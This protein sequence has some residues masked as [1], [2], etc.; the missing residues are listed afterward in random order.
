MKTLL[1]IASAPRSGS[2]LLS[3]L[4]GNFPDHFNVGEIHNL[5]DFLNE[6][7]QGKYFD[8]KCA[9]GEKVRSC[10]KWSKIIRKVV[11]T[12]G[13]VS[14]KELSTRC[15]NDLV[16]FRWR[17]LPR[18]NMA[19]KI[20]QRVQCDQEMARVAKHN[21]CLMEA[22]MEVTGAKLIINSSKNPPTLACYLCHK[23]D[24]WNIKVIHLARDPRA[25][26]L[27]MIKGAVKAGLR[28]KSYY[29]YLLGILNRRRVTECLTSMLRPENVLDLT[30]EEI[31]RSPEQ[32]MRQ[33]LDF[34]KKPS[35]QSLY[36]EKVNQ[37]HDIGGSVGVS[38]VVGIKDI[39][40]DQTW[41]KQMTLSMNL[42]YRV[43]QAF[44]KNQ[45]KY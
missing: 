11:L 24:D 41:K 22:A 27:S 6:G 7:R 43:G 10:S 19:K 42:F 18:S 15:S 35:R 14:D 23:P 21:F 34:L 39:K 30:L 44:F 31:C 4:I 13:L 40:L 12:L 8:G 29:R 38:G 3:N 26:A 5:A 17:C 37:R 28:P 2:T 1:Y 32:S 9:C 16:K 45:H 33:L 25:T 36:T 20:R